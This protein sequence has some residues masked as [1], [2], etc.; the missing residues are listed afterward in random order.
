[1]ASRLSEE[2]YQVCICVE[3]LGRVREIR[4]GE[5]G[6]GEGA[7]ISRKFKVTKNTRFRK[8]GFTYYLL[9]I[10]LTLQIH[11]SFYIGSHPPLP[12]LLASPNLSSPCNTIP[13]S[14]ESNSPSSDKIAASPP[15]N[16]VDVT[17]AVQIAMRKT[18]SLLIPKKLQ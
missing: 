10:F 18:N 6:R 8:V 3:Y 15:S 1:M 7:F 4:T 12:L 14:S 5:V 2:G 9:Y 17:R 11:H 16:Q 13:T